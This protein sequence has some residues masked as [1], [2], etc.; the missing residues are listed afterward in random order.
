MYHNQKPS[1]FDWKNPV[2]IIAIKCQLGFIVGRMM[3]IILATA[4]CCTCI[5]KWVGP[6][7]DWGNVPSHPALLLGAG[8]ENA[9]WRSH[10]AAAVPSCGLMTHS[11][12]MTAAHDWA[13]LWQITVQILCVLKIFCSRQSSPNDLPVY[14]LLHARETILINMKQLVPSILK[15][16]RLQPVA[17]E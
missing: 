3:I 12:E 9:A 6:V 13:L 10:S 17:Q 14:C 2:F 4:Q 15:Q 11:A 1:N 16:E 5:G 8:Y 7:S